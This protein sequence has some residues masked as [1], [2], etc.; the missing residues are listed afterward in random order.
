M[1][2]AGSTRTLRKRT[3][4]LTKWRF[5]SMSCETKRGNPNPR[6]SGSRDGRWKFSHVG[7]GMKL[8]TILHAYQYNRMKQ[9]GW[10]KQFSFTKN[11]QKRNEFES[12]RRTDAKGITHLVGIGRLVV[13]RER[14]CV[15]ERP[16]KEGVVFSR[17]DFDVNRD[18]S[19]FTGS[20]T[21]EKQGRL[22][23]IL[24]LIFKQ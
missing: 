18:I 4:S 21:V 15:R 19:S 1:F 16:F 23:W 14:N 7:S 5:L 8:S 6:A 11:K 13:E 10:V 3:S 9:N 20:V 24:F 17:Q 12:T 22:F 2:L